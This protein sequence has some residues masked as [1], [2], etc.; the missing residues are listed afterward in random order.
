MQIG[1]A[2]GD[3]IEQIEVPDEEVLHFPNGIVGFEDLTNFVLFELEP[4]LY[5]L[6]PADD[7]HTGFVVLDPFLVDPLYRI[8]AR[9]ECELLELDDDDRRSALAVVTL[10]TEGLPQSVNLR[11][12]IVLNASK[13]LG[14]QLILHEDRSVRHPLTVASDGSLLLNQPSTDRGPMARGATAALGR[15]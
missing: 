3:Q 1:V 14:M 15:R 5:L 6:Q 8:P 9:E 2:L 12:P 7:P 4:P 11:A 13:K 10:S